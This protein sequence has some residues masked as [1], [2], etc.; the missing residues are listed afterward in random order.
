MLNERGVT[1]ALVGAE[2][3]LPDAGEGPATGVLAMMFLVRISSGGEVL[4]ACSGL[5]AKGLALRTG[6]GGSAVALSPPTCIGILK[7]WHLRG[8]V[9]MKESSSVETLYRLQICCVDEEART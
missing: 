2:A 5:L 9:C 3:G 4:S 1:P 8:I 7:V 6:V